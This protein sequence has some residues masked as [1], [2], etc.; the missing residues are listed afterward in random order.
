MKRTFSFLLLSTLSA[1]AEPQTFFFAKE[2]AKEFTHIALTIEGDQVTGTQ[3]WQPKEEH[4]SQ[5]T[6]SGIITGGGIIQVVHQYT[7]EGSEQSEEEVLKLDGD[8]LFI[9]EGELVEGKNGRLNLK[10][11]NKVTFKTALK[12][13]SVTEPKAGSPE[14]KAIMDAMRG[15]VT[16]KIGKAV[17][18]TGHVRTSGNWA[19][20]QGN[21]ATADGKAPESEDA[22]AEL[23][24][25]FFALLNKDENGAWQLLHWGFAG[26]IGVSEEAREKHPDAPWVMFE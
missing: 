9:G 10:E 11:P 5:G 20:F 16:A 3:V 2:S 15:P 21:V 14:R 22:A 23:E 25:D 18:F 26:D 7:I 24:L 1:F 12:K 8:K 6:L 13:V 19:R 4:G 17:T